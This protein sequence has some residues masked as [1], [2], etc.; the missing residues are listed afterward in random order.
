MIT[1]NKHQLLE[2]L[3]TDWNELEAYRILQKEPFDFGTGLITNDDSQSE[4]IYW[5]MEQWT[6]DNY[7]N[8][9]E[10]DYYN[11][12]KKKEGIRKN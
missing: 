3:Y 6:I 5:K 7:I 8:V 1:I 4:D 12:N 2:E 10:D 11:I 9:L